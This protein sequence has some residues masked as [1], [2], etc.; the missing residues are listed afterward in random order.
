[1]RSAGLNFRFV[2]SN[3]DDKCDFGNHTWLV[4][5]GVPKMTFVKW[6]M[7]SACLEFRF[8]TS[9]VDDKSDFGNHTWQVALSISEMIFVKR[10]TWT[11]GSDL[12]GATLETAGSRGKGLVEK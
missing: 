6:A 10:A 7:W 9:N 11:A 2:T 4:A 12:K 3:A 5:F 8:V 1:M